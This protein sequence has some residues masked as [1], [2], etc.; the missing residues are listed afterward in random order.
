MIPQRAPT[1][2]FSATW[3]VRAISKGDGV[4][5]CATSSKA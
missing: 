1:Y 5:S 4:S 3:H 2:W